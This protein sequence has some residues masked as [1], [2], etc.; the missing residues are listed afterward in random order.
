M[1]FFSYIY[2]IMK[3]IIKKLL[4]EQSD[5][6]TTDIYHIRIGEDW[7]RGYKHTSDLFF[8]DYDKAVEYLIS[9]GYEKSDYPSFNKSEE[10]WGKGYGYQAKLTT[11]KLI[12]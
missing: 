11:Q 10:N 4:R 12:V 7:D 8:K 5:L 1:T 2:S 9:N 3:K 6:P